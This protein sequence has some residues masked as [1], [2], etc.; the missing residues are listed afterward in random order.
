MAARYL[1]ISSKIRTIE[2]NNGECIF[3]SNLISYRNNDFIHKVV[4]EC[5]IQKKY[6]D[7]ISKKSI[8]QLLFEGTTPK[9][10]RKKEPQMLFMSNV[11]F[12]DMNT[13]FYELSNDMFDYIIRQLEVFDEEI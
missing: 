5:C 6:G 4:E 2:I 12:F 1:S 10:K 13:E 11:A 8:M 3:N 7:M 9:G